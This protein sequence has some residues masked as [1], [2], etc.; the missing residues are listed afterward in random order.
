MVGDV[1]IRF[2][3]NLVLPLLQTCRPHAQRTDHHSVCCSRSFAPPIPPFSRYFVPTSH[4]SAPLCH[5][6]QQGR[7]FTITV[8]ALLK[9]HS[10]SH[11]TRPTT[12]VYSLL[13][14]PPKQPVS[15]ESLGKGGE[16]WNGRRDVMRDTQKNVFRGMGLCSK[17]KGTLHAFF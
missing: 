9:A 3:T 10:T 7:L 15:N 1:L 16:R 6:E 2:T 11:H 14:A 17:R 12:S 8:Y 5:T 13:S 4:P